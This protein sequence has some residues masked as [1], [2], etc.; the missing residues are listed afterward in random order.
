MVVDTGNPLPMLLLFI[1][2]RPLPEA[3]LKKKKQQKK[4][5]LQPK[6]SFEETFLMQ[7]SQWNNH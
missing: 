3:F 7:P 6:E 5:I 2:T 1:I 4:Q